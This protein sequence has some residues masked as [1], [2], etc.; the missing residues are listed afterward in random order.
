MP[1]L[2]CYNVKLKNLKRDVIKINSSET[3]RFQIR[4]GF[5]GT[6][7]IS[8]KKSLINLENG[9]MIFNGTSVFASGCTLS[10]SNGGTIEFG[11]GFAANKNFVVSCN[12]HLVFGDD[13]MLGWNIT[14]FDANGH[15]V[16]KNGIE[17]RNTKP[18]IIGSHVWIGSETHILKGAVVPSNSII[19]YG[20]LV[21]SKF[22]EENCIYGGT[23]AILLDRKT[24]WSR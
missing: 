13:V 5:G 15:S 14:V 18:I 10:V 11:E 3:K 20:S 1:I 4:I 23:P 9:K 7:E 16:Y 2:V 8:S 24:S 19:S 6:Y 17:Q 12:E 22:T 21:V